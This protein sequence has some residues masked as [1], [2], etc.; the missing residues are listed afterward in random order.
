MQLPPAGLGSGYFITSASENVE[1]AE[2]FLTF[3]YDPA[4]AAFWV[5]QMSVIP[6]NDVDTSTL[7]VS[8]LLAQT[9]DALATVQMGYNIDVLTRRP[10]PLGLM[11][12]QGAYTRDIG[13]IAAG[14]SLS[15][16]PVIIV[17]LIFQRQFVK[18]LTAGAVK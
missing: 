9:M 15:T 6:P 12:F 3:L 8:P 4:N 16:I 2:K 17:Y 5:E 10:I 18:G 14:V 7:D 13:L 11:F 1:A